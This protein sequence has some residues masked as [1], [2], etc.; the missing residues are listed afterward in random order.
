MY[1]IYYAYTSP[2]AERH[3]EAH[4]EG[5]LI[6]SEKIKAKVKEYSNKLLRAFV[7]APRVVAGEI[8]PGYAQPLLRSAMAKPPYE[9]RIHEGPK[10]WQ[11]GWQIGAQINYNVGDRGRIEPAEESA[12]IEAKKT[13]TLTAEVFD[14]DYVS[15]RAYKHELAVDFIYHQTNM[16][17]SKLFVKLYL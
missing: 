9:G 12:R 16:L 17:I 10:L 2:G 3:L 11:W 8:R 13:A 15:L 5:N 6:D 1:V 4:F 14:Y 7:A